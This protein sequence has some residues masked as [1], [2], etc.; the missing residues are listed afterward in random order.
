MFGS[1]PSV[2]THVDYMLEKVYKKLWTLRN[3]KRAG[4]NEEDM[5]K[6]FNAI[7]RPICDYATP[8]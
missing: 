7:I 3:I 5:L 8:T 1:K 2:G 4:M 6:I